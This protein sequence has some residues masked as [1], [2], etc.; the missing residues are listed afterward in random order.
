MI[1]GLMTD[2]ESKDFEPFLI[3][4]VGHPAR[5][6]RRVLGACFGLAD[7]D[8]RAVARPTGGVRQLEFH[9]S[10]IPSLG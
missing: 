5:N 1:R 10:A 2:D 4:R 6:Y 7:A 9:L 3:R 8:R